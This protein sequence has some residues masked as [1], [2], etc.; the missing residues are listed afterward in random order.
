MLYPRSRVLYQPPA[1]SD[2]IV[3]VFSCVERVRLL[4][5]LL[6]LLL[7]VLQRFRVL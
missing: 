1:T 6:P 2:V 4:D 5:G 3:R 7:V